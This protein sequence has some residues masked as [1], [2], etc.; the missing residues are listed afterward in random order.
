MTWACLIHGTASSRC[1]GGVGVEVEHHGVGAGAKRGGDRGVGGMELA[2]DGD[3]RDAEAGGDGEMLDAAGQRVVSAR[4]LA[5]D[6][7]AIDESAAEKERAEREPFAARVL[8]DAA[9]PDGASGCG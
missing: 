6:H 2:G 4:G 7:G 9:E 5:A 8:A 3:A 1:L